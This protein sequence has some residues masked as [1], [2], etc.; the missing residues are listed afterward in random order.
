MKILTNIQTS[1]LA[2]IT[3][4]FASFIDF[5]ERSKK[6]N[7][8]ITGINVAGNTAPT[9]GKNYQK[10]KGRFTLVSMNRSYPNI[11]DLTQKATSLS[12]I[13]DSYEEI[14]EKHREIIKTQKPDVILLN[15]T[16]YKPWWLYIASRDF[17]I[18]IILHYHGILSKEVAH[19]EEKQRVLF[20]QME[21]SFD[22]SSLFYIF[23]S[24]LAKNVVENEVFGHPIIRSA[25]LPNS[26]P[27]YFF[28]IKRNKNSHGIGMVSRWSEV[29]NPL[30]ARKIANYNKKHNGK[31]DVNMV[32]DLAKSNRHYQQV[33]GLVNILSPMSNQQL[34]HFYGK[35]SVVLS[36]SVFETYGN[37][38][39]EALACGTPALVSSNMGVAETFNKVGLQD[40]IVNFNSVHNIYEKIQKV[41]LQE[42][43]PSVKKILA[44]EYSPETINSKLFSIFRSI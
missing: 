18:P 43:N 36:P 11:R 30:F 29:K 33:N 32:T 35:M 2:G 8:H 38:A 12:E 6:K 5:S 28:N 3:Q 23:P 27:G 44:E 4:T 37:V 15:G 7:I 25:I 21:K 10:T 13:E 42:V 40:W 17:N 19:L 16:Y 24:V 14:I 39:Q 20:E 31:F 34:G 26:I 41:S 1:P 9:S 22:E